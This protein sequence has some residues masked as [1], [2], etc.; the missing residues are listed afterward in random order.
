MTWKTRR[1]DCIGREPGGKQRV[2]LKD[3]NKIDAD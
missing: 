3:D 1:R 2:T